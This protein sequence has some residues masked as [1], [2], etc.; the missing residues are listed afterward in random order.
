MIDDFKRG[1]NLCSALCGDEGAMPSAVRSVALLLLLC[2]AG[3]HE[4]VQ[5]STAIR[6]LDALTP[7]TQ[8]DCSASMK[9]HGGAGPV[10]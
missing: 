1:L 9:K 3:S 2:V 4:L 10:S 5:V 6:A 8:K 7:P